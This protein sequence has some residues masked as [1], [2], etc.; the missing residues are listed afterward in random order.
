MDS[1]SR[2]MRVRIAHLLFGN[3]PISGK[4]ATHLASRGIIDNPPS[5]IVNPFESE[6]A[7]FDGPLIFFGREGNQCGCVPLTDLLFSSDSDVRLKA[8][9]RLRKLTFSDLRLADVVGSAADGLKAENFTFEALRL[10]HLIKSDW[11]VNLSAL[12]QCGSVNSGDIIYD[13]LQLVLLPSV[14]AVERIPIPPHWETLEDPSPNLLSVT[15]LVTLLGECAPS[16]TLAD[17]RGVIDVLSPEE[18]NPEDDLV[19]R[20]LLACDGQFNRLLAVCALLGSNAHL[21]VNCAEATRQNVVAALKQV[22]DPATLDYRGKLAAHFMCH[23]ESLASHLDGEKAALLAWWMADKV[24][25]VSGL[26]DFLCSGSLENLSDRS[27]LLRQLSRPNVPPHCLRYLTIWHPVL[28]L[29]GR[30]SACFIQDVQLKPYLSE[31]GQDIED[32]TQSYCALWSRLKGFGLQIAVGEHPIAR[33]AQPLAS[34][35]NGCLE[36]LKRPLSNDLEALAASQFFHYC[37]YLAPPDSDDLKAVDELV[38]NP[39][40]FHRF[41]ESLPEAA[42]TMVIDGLTEGTASG[43][44]PWANF[45]TSIIF[46]NLE[47]AQ[48]SKRSLWA[49]IL[50]VSATAT[51]DGQALRRLSSLQWRLELKEVTQSWRETLVALIED[52][53]APWLR[54]RFGN[55]LLSLRIAL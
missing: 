43:R 33:S 55:T 40:D 34:G 46:Q 7:G 17:L 30:L 28:L 31:L 9:D 18:L 29:I 35:A 23:L 2:E 39:D 1:F 14:E 36:L 10:E 22:M 13:Y 3:T 5:D 21:V 19:T 48:P 27:M 12:A 47:R 41:L 54:G 15:S 37:C 8:V 24:A 20:L 53:A 16:S 50:I 52:G 42:L 25:S 45:L 51:D 32:F 11:M 26:T 44:A 49:N 38:C 6:V 4:V